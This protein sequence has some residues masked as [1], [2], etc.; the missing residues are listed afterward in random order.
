M[1]KRLV[2]FFNADGLLKDSSVLFA[3]MAIAHVFNLLFQMF[4]GRRLA[5][6]EF[7]LLI[8]MLGIFNIL[9][10]PLGVVS[11][12]IN[13]YSSLLVKEGRLGDVRRLLGRW[14]LRMGVIG[15]G[16]AAICFLFPLQVAGFFH[17]ERA[18]PV[19]ILG[20][21]VSG[22][23]CR[24]VVNGALLGL[25]RFPV[26]CLGTVLGAAVRLFVGAALVISISPFAG[27]GLL[28][29]GLGFYMTV[30]LGGGVLVFLLRG[31]KPT[32]E[33]LPKM[34]GFMFGSFFIILGY[35]ILMTGDVVLVKHLFPQAA[36]DFAFAATLGRLVLFIPN[37]FVGAMFPKVVAGEGMGGQ[38]KRLL[39][40]TL[41]ITFLS[42]ASVAFVLSV[43]ASFFARLIFDISEPSGDLVIWCTVHSW[44]MVIIALLNVL[45][46]FV[47]ARHKLGIG[48]FV[49]GAAVC[50]ILY[51]FIFAQGP[52]EVLLGL[53]AASLSAVLVLGCYVFWAE[54]K[55]S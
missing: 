7:A 31:L 44:L 34:Q 22:M 6:E 20:I 8:S 17:L 42:T 1:I 39:V 9:T 23:F 25:Q 4:M 13:R 24:P 35:S 3:G 36:G 27:W 47:L 29:H 15:G 54:R 30:L 10:L 46:R 55:E 18:A 53:G 52:D 51:S 14:G 45:Y 28:G 11:S 38:Q 12:A 43:G 32:Q 19:Y 16:L 49:A 48:A 2:Q 5:P 40:R 41:L 26:W 37:A 50:Y 33:P 21:I